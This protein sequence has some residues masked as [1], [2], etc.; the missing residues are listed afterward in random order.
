MNASLYIF[1]ACDFLR[2]QLTS[3]YTLGYGIHSPFLFAI[4]EQILPASEPYYAFLDI[5][6]LRYKL[7]R[8]KKRI[9]VEDYGTG[10]SEERAVSAIA[11]RSLKSPREAQ[12]L[13]RL[14]V[15]LH[16]REIVE[17][18][19]SLG[20][21]TAYLASASSDARVTTFEGAPEVA[22]LAED[23][24]KRLGLTN[25][26]CVEGPI[27]ETFIKYCA[28]ARKVDLCFMDA[29]HTSKATLRYF[30][31]LLPMAHEHSV[32]VLDDIHSSPDMLKAWRDIC[33]MPEVTATFDIY[34]MG[35]VFFNKNFEKKTYNI[36]F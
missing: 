21:T 9:F 31:Q 35:L 13:M 20:L 6:K 1:R 26:Q 2:H 4:A 34:S 7:Q 36:R 19:T 29:N 32:F 14:A 28:P 3:R 16:A 27:D 23:N 25:I 30:R 15:M 17:L 18:G 12:L 10:T 5:E 22:R 11:E 8:S 24:W 33:A